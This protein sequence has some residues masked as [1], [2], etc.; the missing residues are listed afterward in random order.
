MRVNSVLL[1]IT[2]ISLGSLLCLILMIL[3]GSIG[4]DTEW[5]QPAT[6]ATLIGGLG[7]AVARLSKQQ[8]VKVRLRFVTKN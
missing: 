3:H 2:Y 4:F 6:I 1:C 7:G 8:N 5:I